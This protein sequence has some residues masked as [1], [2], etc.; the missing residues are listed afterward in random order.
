MQ[1]KLRMSAEA[2]SQAEHFANLSNVGDGDMRQFIAALMHLKD[3]QDLYNV[4][5]NIEKIIPRLVD[6][7][8][9][10][11]I[12]PTDSFRAANG[13]LWSLYSQWRKSCQDSMMHSMYDHFCK[14]KMHDVKCPTLYLES[15]PIQAMFTMDDKRYLGIGYDAANVNGLGKDQWVLLMSVRGE[16]T[17]STMC[18]GSLNDAY[19]KID[20]DKFGQIVQRLKGWM[21]EDVREFQDNPTGNTP[22]PE[23]AQVKA[24]FQE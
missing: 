19:G 1:L 24:P 11:K 17:G 15:Y 22:D 4:G 13:R 6:L 12:E 5:L 23:A 21:T 7:F 2:H 10:A 16:N 3:M 18:M 9:E 20:F 14:A 8:K